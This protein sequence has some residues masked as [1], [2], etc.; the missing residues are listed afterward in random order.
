M[1]KKKENDYF[2]GLYEDMTLEELNDDVI[3]NL[4][5]IKTAEVTKKDYV[6][7]AKETINECKARL[8]AVIYWIGVKETEK[9][10]L[11]LEDAAEEALKE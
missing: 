11:A 6:D 7:S 8:D 1:A 3:K 5:R 4:K 2:E 9:E 10:R